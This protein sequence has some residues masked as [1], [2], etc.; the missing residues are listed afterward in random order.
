MNDHERAVALLDGITENVGRIR[1]RVDGGWRESE[2]LDPLCER[3]H[4]ADRLLEEIQETV[5]HRETSR[6]APEPQRNSVGKAQQATD[7]KGLLIGGAI[8]AGFMMFVAAADGTGDS[9][10]LFFGLL[11]TAVFGGAGWLAGAKVMQ[12]M[13]LLPAVIAG[14][15]AWVVLAGFLGE[16]GMGASSASFA[17]MFGAG[18]WY[19]SRSNVPPA[20]READPC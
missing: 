2:S 19:S 9:G 17:A 7:W 14:F 8:V 15:V 20:D 4:Q 10:V 16:I 12:R 11:T 6:D 18:A 3:L 5:E 1:Q 13:S